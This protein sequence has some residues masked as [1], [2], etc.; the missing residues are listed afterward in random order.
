MGLDALI[1]RHVGLSHRGRWSL[2]SG[3]FC[4]KKFF[5]RSKS[6]SFERRTE[7]F[8]LI[9]EEIYLTSGGYVVVGAKRRKY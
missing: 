3:H 9:T 6:H 4:D 2:K 5:L 8:K 1:A 7:K